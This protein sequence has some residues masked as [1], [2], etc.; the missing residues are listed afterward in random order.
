MSI[1]ATHS[2]PVQ[3]RVAKD[4]LL[5]TLSGDALRLYLY[6]S[7]KSF[8]SRKHTHLFMDAELI[9][10]LGITKHL[11]PDVRDELQHADLI[12]YIVPDANLAV[13]TLILDF[14]PIKPSGHDI[15]PEQSSPTQISR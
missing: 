8:R 3:R 14:K 4:S 11:L 2:F 15:Y 13:Y 7:Y 10:D 1:L 9:R 12:T 5:R 6:L